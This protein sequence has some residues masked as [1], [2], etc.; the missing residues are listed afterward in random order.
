VNH[1]L[2]NT[3]SY[4]W[5]L[6]GELSDS[7][8][9][10]VTAYDAAGNA[11]VDESDSLVHVVSDG[12]VAADAGPHV[13]ALWRPLPNPSAGAVQLRFALPSSGRARMEVV[14]LSGRRVWSRQEELGAGAHAW[15]WDGRG[16]GGAQ[17]RAGLYFLR[18]TTPWGSQTE[19]LVRLT[20]R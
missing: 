14:D 5:T 7:A 1:A 9:V 13:L 18:L 20:G 10:R 17:A 11:G 6:P 16:A 12:P 4:V 8:V 2:P 19:R 15:A 3:G